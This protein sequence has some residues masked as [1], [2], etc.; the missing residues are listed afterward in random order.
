MALIGWLC[1][2]KVWVL[3][4]IVIALVFGFEHPEAADIM[5][6]VLIVQMT[7]ALDGLRFSRTD[8]G[9][10]SRDM[11]LCLVLCFL[12]N[13]PITLLIGSLF[14]DDTALWYGWVMLASVPCAVSVVTAALYMRGDV[15]LAMMGLTAV[16]VAS[17]AATPVLTFLLLGEAV[18]PVEMLR[19]IVLFIAVPFILCIPLRRLNLPRVPKVIG[20]NLFMFLMVLI[21]LGTRRDF[22]FGQPG[23]VGWLI[24]ASLLRV[25]VLGFSVMVLM[26]RSG[27]PRGRGIPLLMMT[28]WRNSGLSV[29]LCMA[30]LGALYPA[31]VLPCAVSLMVETIWFAVAM[32]VVDRVWPV[33]DSI[34]QS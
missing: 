20:I 10:Y 1:D 11:V 29:S 27:V 16:Y 6:L 8:L 26:A 34:G 30:L 7:L 3:S 31:A 19:Y 23:I 21:A 5:V 9:T 24:A 13:T 17:L 28:T 14:M 22:I 33:A 18:D 4:A 12:V 32:A 25:F 2:V 15:K